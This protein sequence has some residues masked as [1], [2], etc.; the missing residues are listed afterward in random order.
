[1]A[2]YTPHGTSRWIGLPVASRHEMLKRTVMVSVPMGFL[3]ASGAS[4]LLGRE[5]L[6]TAGKC[7]S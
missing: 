5:K 1:M 3:E 4:S 6:V 2:T 7:Q